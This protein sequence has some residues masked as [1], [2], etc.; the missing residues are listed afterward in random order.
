MKSTITKN[1]YLQLVGLLTLA[2][3]HNQVLRDISQSA[4]LITGDE[5][6]GHTDDA[7]YCDYP[8]EDL[9]KLAKITIEN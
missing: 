7:I 5:E 3:K 4:A 6:H 8:V 1:E 2:K 9:L